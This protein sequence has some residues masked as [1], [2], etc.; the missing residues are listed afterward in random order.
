[1]S[2]TQNK[3]TTTALPE[4]YIGMLSPEKGK[5]STPRSNTLADD[6]VKK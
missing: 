3:L 2:Y 5:F 4:Q 6:R 1:M